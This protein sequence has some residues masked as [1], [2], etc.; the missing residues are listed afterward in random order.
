MFTV[1]ALDAHRNRL[2]R[3]RGGH[4]L[5]HPVVGVN[6]GAVKFGN[7]IAA[8]DTGCISGAGEFYVLDQNALDLGKPHGLGDIFGHAVDLQSGKAEFGGNGD[9]PRTEEQHR[10]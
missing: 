4:R 10:Q 8:A 3:L 1:A 9:A 5:D 6:L 7:Q 2:P